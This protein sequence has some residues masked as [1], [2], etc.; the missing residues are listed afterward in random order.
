MWELADFSI[1]QV[2]VFCENS[3]VYVFCE[4][5]FKLTQ[6]QKECM[7]NKQQKT[8]IKQF[9]VFCFFYMPHLG[10]PTIQCGS[11]IMANNSGQTERLS[12][13]YTHLLRKCLAQL[14]VTPLKC[15]TLYY[16]GD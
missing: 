3:H 4:I 15:F 2:Y 12:I 7:V 1:T 6:I 9:L 13:E 11:V 16:I 14:H 8:L 10:Q 5:A